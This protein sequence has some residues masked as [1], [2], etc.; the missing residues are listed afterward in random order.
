MFPLLTLSTL[1]LMMHESATCLLY[2]GCVAC[3]EQPDDE[4]DDED[5]D[6]EEQDD[7]EME[8]EDVSVLR[9]RE[10]ELRSGC[11]ELQSL[12]DS[13]EKSSATFWRELERD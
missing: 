10:E 1:T 8:E 6:D 5:D 12:G 13:E 3:G 4:D 7:E 11:E 9:T 2:R